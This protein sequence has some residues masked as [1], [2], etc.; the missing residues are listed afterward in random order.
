MCARN[1]TCHGAVSISSRKEYLNAVSLAYTGIHQLL[2]LLF[3]VFYRVGM[4]RELDK[5]HQITTSHPK[6]RAKLSPS[7]WM[8]VEPQRR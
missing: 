1:W 6:L 2:Q 3:A 5:L 7:F 4:R 8:L